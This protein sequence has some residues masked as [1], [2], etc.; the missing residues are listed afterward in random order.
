M[1]FL[2]VPITSVSYIGFNL[3]G[4]SE[5]VEHVTRRATP[6][7]TPQTRGELHLACVA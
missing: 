1:P 3:G 6:T 7:T 4:V 2:F 5:L